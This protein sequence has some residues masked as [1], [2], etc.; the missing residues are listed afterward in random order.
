MSAVSSET[1]LSLF[2]R[3][4]GRREF[5]GLGA[6]AGG[7]FLLAACGGGSSGSEAGSGSTDGV[8][9]PMHPPIGQEPGKLQVYDYAGYE[10][11]PLWRQYAKEHPDDPPKW[12]FL[13]SDAEALSTTVAGYRADVVHPCSA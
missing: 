10:V 4:V 11:K 1:N 13:N 12:K 3:R 9:A 8:T 5:L 6:L 7:S 2:E